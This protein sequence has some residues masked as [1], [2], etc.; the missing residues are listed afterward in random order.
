MVIFPV[1]YRSLLDDPSWPTLMGEYAVECS[2]PELGELDPQRDLYAAMEAS[3]GLQCFG[4][5]AGRLVGFISLITWTVPHYG[6]TIV[7]TE[8]I[9]LSRSDRGQ[10]TGLRMLD[11]VVDFGREKKARMVQ[12][13]APAGSRL[14]KLLSYLDPWRH[15]NDVFVRGL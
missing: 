15:S 13:T 7:S 6:K 10:N 2:L 4:V 5:Y 12:I 3:G 14:G 1:T 11:F 9:F 8:S